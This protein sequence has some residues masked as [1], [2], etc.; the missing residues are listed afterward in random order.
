MRRTV[1][2]HE[3]A[4]V[5]ARTDAR[6]ARRLVDVDEQGP[7]LGLTEA[8]ERGGCRWEEAGSTWGQRRGGREG[9]QAGGQ[10]TSR[11]G[12]ARPRGREEERAWPRLRREAQ[13]MPEASVLA[14]V[15]LSQI[16]S[17]ALERKYDCGPSRSTLPPR[18]IVWRSM[19]DT[20]ARGGNCGLFT[21]GGRGVRA[22]GKEGSLAAVPSA[23][24]ARRGEGEC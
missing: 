1:L 15:P 17:A 20:S 13:S 10:R 22:E 14:E 2:R 23:G 5:G 7:Q 11:A 19:N 18:A 24:G 3:G 21:C 9:G 6:R 8:R 16:F 4:G 12:R